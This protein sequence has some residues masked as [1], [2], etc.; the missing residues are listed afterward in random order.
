M[1][2][3]E[4]GGLRRRHDPEEGLQITMKEWSPVSK[5][6]RIKVDGVTIW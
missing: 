6:K 2:I 4:K 3:S 5:G 1:A